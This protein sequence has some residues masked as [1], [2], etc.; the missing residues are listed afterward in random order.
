M[1]LLNNETLQSS[2]GGN[3]FFGVKM[4]PLKRCSVVGSEEVIEITEVVFLL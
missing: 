1:W 2:L 3:F 4:K